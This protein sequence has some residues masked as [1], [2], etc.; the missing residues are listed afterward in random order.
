MKGAISCWHFSNIWCLSHDASACCWC[1]YWPPNSQ[2][3]SSSSSLVRGHIQARE[4]ILTQRMMLK[5]TRSTAPVGEEEQ[6]HLLLQMRQQMV[7]WMLVSGHSELCRSKTHDGQLQMQPYEAAGGPHSCVCGADSRVPC[8]KPTLHKSL[9]F[10]CCLLFTDEDGGE[11]AEGGAADDRVQHNKKRKPSAVFT[12]YMP[13]QLTAVSGH[14]RLMCC[15]RPELCNKLHRPPSSALSTSDYPGLWSEDTGSMQQCILSLP[16]PNNPLLKPTQ[17]R[18]NCPL[19]MPLNTGP[20][21][22]DFFSAPALW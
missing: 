10:S 18:R 8:C 11:Q 9:L 7:L 14:L 21:P 5:T 20:E 13:G 1:R 6:V 4:T 16:L 15:L 22:C 17:G 3:E 12:A 2:V 19:Y